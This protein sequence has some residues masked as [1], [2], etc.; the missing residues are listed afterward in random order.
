LYGL[1]RDP[2]TEAMIAPA[3]TPISPAAPVRA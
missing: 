1:A 2:C 3:R